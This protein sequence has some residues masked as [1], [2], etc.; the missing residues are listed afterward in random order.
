MN[1]GKYVFA[2]IADFLP[3]RVF[4][5]CVD[6]YSGNHYVKHFKCWN[7]LLCMMFG[8]LSGR[9][10]L[11]DLLTTISAHRPKYYH[12]G[13][14]KNVSRSN[15]ANANELRDYR[16]FEEMAYELIA[17]ARSCCQQDADFALSIDNP[18]YAF[19]STLIDLCLNVFWWAEF[20]KAKAAVKIHTLY[21]IRTSIPCFIHI[22]DGATHD[23]HGLDVLTYEANGFYILDRG[24]VDFHRLY[25]I[26]QQKAFF[27]TRAKDNF[28]FTRLN[29]GVPDKKAGVTCDQCVK[30]KGFY[31]SKHYPDGIR[32][33]RFIDIE[34]GRKMVFLTNNF[35][36]PAVDIA[37]LYK[38]RWKVELFFKWIK[39]HLKVKSF[40]GTS[41]N[42]VKTQV[43]IAIITY[44]LVAIIKARMKSSLTTY[45]IL[46]ILSAS[47]L[48]KTPLKVLLAN[49]NNQDFK[50]QND[51]QL[52]INLI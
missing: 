8:Q 2:Q 26:N 24:Y 9:E 11:R 40:W 31:T 34:T 14:G 32:R 16:I 18:V 37:L 22:T 52:K 15:L 7:Q 13:F 47:L 4:D 38:Y 33:I 42:A 29:A 43:Y 17:E 20:R 50:E 41:P 35:D 51:I 21:D 48:D 5:R 30:P 27:V 1:Q 45:E 19:D 6:N 10:S 28:K 46:Q 36:L 3:S 23:V 39:Q 25:N 44:S 12:L 49:Q